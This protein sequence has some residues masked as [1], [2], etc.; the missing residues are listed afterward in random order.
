MRVVFEITVAEDKNAYMIQQRYNK[1]YKIEWN[2]SSVILD[3]VRKYNRVGI[4]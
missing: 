1:G 2:V 3:A 4:R